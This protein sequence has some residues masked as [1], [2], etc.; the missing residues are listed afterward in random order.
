MSEINILQPG[1]YTSIQDL[2]RKEFMHYGVPVSGAMDNFSA[3]KA[4]LLVNNQENAAVL[5]ITMTGPTLDFQTQTEIA[6]CGAQF[7]V[8]LNNSLIS[9]SRLYT[10]PPKSILKFGALQKGFRA[11]LAVHGGFQTRQVLGSRSFY[12]EITEKVRLQKGD[13]LPINVVNIN[14]SATNSRVSFEDKQLWSQEIPVYK[15]PEYDFLPSELKE[16]LSRFSFTLTPASNRMAIPFQ[17]LMPNNLKGIVT[18]PVLPGTIQLTPSGILIALMRD[19]QI[20][21]GYPRIFQISEPGICR[22]SQKK[23]GESVCFRLIELSR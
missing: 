13:Q 6:I 14:N 8:Y 19:C 10:I 9:N 15:G 3:K 12:S 5:E 16:Q 11:Y 21:G 23:P 1:F 2:G 7:E 17:E 20:T 22:L 4:N 18:A